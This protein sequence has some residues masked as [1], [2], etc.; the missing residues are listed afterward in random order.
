MLFWTVD[1]STILFELLL[2]TKVWSVDLWPRSRPILCSSDRI[3]Q[4]SRNSEQSRRLQFVDLLELTTV[5]YAHR[6]PRPDI[7][8]VTL[9]SSTYYVAECLIG[10]TSHNIQKSQIIMQKMKNLLLW[11]FFR[12]FEGRYNKNSSFSGQ[13]PKVSVWSDFSKS[14][15]RSRLISLNLRKFSLHPSH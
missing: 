3:I 11:H 15:P 14:S 13:V 4:R 12:I 8:P 2:D 6:K 7:E 10:R 9:K 5:F 1:S